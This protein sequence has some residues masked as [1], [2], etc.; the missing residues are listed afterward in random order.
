MKKS[1]FLNYF[2]ENNPH[3]FECRLPYNAQKTH[4]LLTSVCHVIF[5]DVI[6]EK[7]VTEAHKN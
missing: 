5:D 7:S 4:I 1:I 3:P 2:Y 6:S